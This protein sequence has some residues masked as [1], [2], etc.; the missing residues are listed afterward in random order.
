MAEFK[1]NM[2]MKTQSVDMNRIF[3]ERVLIDRA[4]DESYLDAIDL[5]IRFDAP[6]V[7]WEDG[8]VVHYGPERLRALKEKSLES[9]RKKYGADYTPAPGS[10][11]IL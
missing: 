10:Q 8:K 2:E 9:Y 11:L 1:E 6:M 4:L 5:H 3:A 7:F